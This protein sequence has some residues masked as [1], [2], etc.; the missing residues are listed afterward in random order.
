MSEFTVLSGEELIFRLQEHFN[1]GYNVAKK[2]K[3]EIEEAKEE[4]RAEAVRE[5]EYKIQREVRNAPYISTT[6]LRHILAEVKGE[7]K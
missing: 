1:F 2:I 6:I 3:H 4:G 7:G 5:I